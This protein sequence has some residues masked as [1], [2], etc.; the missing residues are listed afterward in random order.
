MTVNRTIVIP[1]ADVAAARTS[2]EMIPGC[3]GMF[4]SPVTLDPNGVPGTDGFFSSGQMP[5]E[6]LDIMWSSA[7]I[8][9]LATET[10]QQTIERAGFFMIRFIDD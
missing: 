5:D 7:T 10:M 4:M 1:A 8:G 9:D 3:V 2:V 6:V